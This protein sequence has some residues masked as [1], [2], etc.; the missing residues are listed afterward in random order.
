MTKAPPELKE[1]EKAVKSGEYN[2]PLFHNSFNPL[3]PC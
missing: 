3:S 2:C 1:W